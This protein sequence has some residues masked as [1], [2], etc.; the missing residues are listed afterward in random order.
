MKWLKKNIA[1]LLSASGLL[2]TF[3]GLLLVCAQ[4]KQANEHHKWNNYNQLDIHY[5][6]LYRQLPP[7]LE[8]AS[9]KRFEDLEPNSKTWIRSYFNLCAEKYYLFLKHLI[10]EEM[11]TKQIDNGIE[12]NMLAYP[13]IIEGYEYGKKRRSFTHPKEFY[14]FMDNKISI[15]TPRI[16]EVLAQC[17]KPVTPNP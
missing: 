7:E 3:F 12:V 17:N 15:L 10:P 2:L 8:A 13:V 11:W 16:I 5:S 6:N 14:A 1:H 4:L 9:C